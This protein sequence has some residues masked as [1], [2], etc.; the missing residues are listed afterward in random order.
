MDSTII[1]GIFTL[2]GM[3]VGAVATIIAAKIQRSAK[4]NDKA[5]S[6]LASQVKA[7]WAL[8]EEYALELK[9]YLGESKS[10]LKKKLRERVRE[11]GYAEP[12]MTAKDVDKL[13]E[14]L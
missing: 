11:K 14:N 2:S 7:Y 1:T 12:N 4:R 10:S 6:R 3:V 13:L 5:L 8:E 9:D